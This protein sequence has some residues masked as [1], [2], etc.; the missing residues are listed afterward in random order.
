MSQ[1]LI[2]NYFVMQMCVSPFLVCVDRE[3]ESVVIS[4]RGTLSLE[5][6]LLQTFMFQ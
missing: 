5:V 6:S 4:V 2:L 3:K 1:K